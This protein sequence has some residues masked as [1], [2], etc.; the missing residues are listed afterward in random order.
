MDALLA[1]D[2]QRL[3]DDP[4]HD[5]EVARLARGIAERHLAERPDQERAAHEV[6]LVVRPA[7]A[8][9]FLV[10]QSRLDPQPQLLLRELRRAL[11]A[12]A[13]ARGEGDMDERQPDG[14][15]DQER[16]RPATEAAASHRRGG[17][18][19]RLARR[20]RGLR[21]ARGRFALIGRARRP[22][23]DRR[24]RNC[25]RLDRLAQARTSLVSPSRSAPG[26]FTVQSALTKSRVARVVDAPGGVVS[27]GGECK[28][29]TKTVPRALREAPRLPDLPPGPVRRRL[30]LLVN[31]FYP[32]DPHASFGKHVL[33]PSLAL[34]SIARRDAR[35]L[36][37]ALLGRE[38][39]PGP[40]AARPVARGRRDH[41]APHLRRRALTSWRAGTARAAAKVVLGGLH[42]LSCPEECAPH[43]DALAVGEGVQVWPEILRDVERGRSRAALRRQLPAPVSRRP[44]AA[45]AILPRREL[46]HDDQPDRHARLPQPLRVLLPG[47]RRPARCRTRSRDVE[48]VVR[49]V[50]GRRAALCASSSTTT[51]ARG[52][53]TS[54]GSAGRCGRSRRSGAPRSR[55]T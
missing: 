10:A 33:T 31:P 42:V 14:D 13:L 32:K 53:T 49:R 27:P 41:R 19:C 24:G 45:R 38:P 17:S 40:A 23:A 37:G 54:G 16:Q 5:L 43:A 55:S 50:P 36:G 15:S 7:H 20:R 35:R 26:H 6:P 1:L 21:L 47:D 25:R 8:R 4:V 12:G 18:G 48:Q 28:T 2:G 52:P 44:A 51:S 29:V 39:A 9:D 30:A 46:P 22:R 3:A 34:T 11:G